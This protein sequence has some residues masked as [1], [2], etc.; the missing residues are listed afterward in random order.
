MTKLNTT[1][2]PRPN[3]DPYVYPPRD[4]VD[5][6]RMQKLLAIQAYGNDVRAEA[7]AVSNKEDPR[8]LPVTSFATAIRMGAWWAKAIGN[9]NLDDSGQAVIW[10]P[11]TS[12]GRVLQAIKHSALDAG[13][14][15]VMPGI[16]AINVETATKSQRALLPEDTYQVWHELEDLAARMNA[17]RL[18][19][20]FSDMTWNAITESLDEL[21]DTLRE[22]IKR[23]AGTG[24]DVVI[25]AS[26]TLGE[27]LVEA[28]APLARASNSGHI[29]M[30]VLGGFIGVAGLLY[31]SKR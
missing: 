5:A 2:P 7:W 31:L 23:A 1:T 9:A 15:L 4:F 25:W 18:A 22:A 20:K 26:R 28:L 16:D 24:G 12:L 21:P 10:N 8:A 19:P 3:F 11:R 30:V 13:G 14:D 17:V 29:G 6:W 27:A